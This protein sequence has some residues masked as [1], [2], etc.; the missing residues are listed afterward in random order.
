MKRYRKLILLALFMAA[1]SCSPE[2]RIKSGDLVFVGLPADYGA[3]SSSMS[4]GISAATGNG[5]GLNYIHAGILEAEGDSLWV[6]DATIKRGVARYP[7]DSFLVDFTLRD[8][9]LPVFEIMRFKKGA[10]ELLKNAK[11]YIG[12]PYDFHFLP[13]N[14]AMYCTEL[15]RDAYLDEEGRPILPEAPMNFKSA[16]GEFAPYW[17]KLFGSLGVPVPQDVPGTNPNDMRSSP[18]LKHVFDL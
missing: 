16:D 6:I 2:K 13:D 9:S 1:A 12:Q 17:Q 11:K 18:L 8:G 14:G 7:L 4:S 15:V 10:R 3:D 5:S